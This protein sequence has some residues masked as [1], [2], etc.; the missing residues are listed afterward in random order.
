MFEIIIAIAS[1][2]FDVV[3]VLM[4]QSFLPNYFKKKGE[5]LATKQDIGRITNIVENIK[6]DLSSELHIKQTRYLKEYEILADLTEKVVDL[7]DAARGLRPITEYVDPNE[8]ED[9]RK[10]R[11][12]QVY[13]GAA[14]AFYRLKEN[15][16]P[17]FPKPIYDKLNSLDQVAW[18]EAINYKNGIRNRHVDYWTQAEAGSQTIMRQANDLIETI[19]DWVEMWNKKNKISD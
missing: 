4:L 13:Q 14:R 17:F 2:V 19:R 7:R 16:R 1:I 5:N 15:K 6:A 12:L 8:S 9:E 3:V 10:R 18:D 11:K